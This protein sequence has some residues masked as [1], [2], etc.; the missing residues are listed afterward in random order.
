MASGC[1]ATSSSSSIQIGTKSSSTVLTG[2]ALTEKNCAR[3]LTEAGYGFEDRF[4]QKSPTRAILARMI[5]NLLAIY[6][7]LD[8]PLKKYRLPRFIEILGCEQREEGL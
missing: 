2:G 6:S 3:F 1:L 4:L 7:K 5:K 8:E